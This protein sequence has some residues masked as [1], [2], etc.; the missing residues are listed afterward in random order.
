LAIVNTFI[1]RNPKGENGKECRQS[2]RGRGSEKED[3][4]L[5]KNRRGLGQGS[6]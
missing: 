1:I 3:K 2:R 6:P 5:V 4:T